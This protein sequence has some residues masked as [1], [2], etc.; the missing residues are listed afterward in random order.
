MAHKT[1]LLQKIDSLEGLTT[2]EKAQLKALLNTQ[3]KYGLVWEDKPEEVERQLLENLP[4]LVE[5]KERYIAASQPDQVEKTPNKKGISAAQLSLSLETAEENPEN[6]SDPG[7]PPS[8]ELEGASDN[9][10]APHHILI[11][12]D[13]LHALTALSFT[14]K[15]KI[16]VIYIDPPYNTGN[17]DF[18]YNDTFVDKE[19]SYRHSKWLSFMHKRLVLAKQLLKDTGVIFI[20]IDDNEQAQIKLLCD[21]VFVEQNFISNMIWSAGKKNDSKYISNSHEYVLAY[22]KNVSIIKSLKIKWRERKQGIDRIYAAAEKALLETHFDYPAATKSLKKWFKTLADNDPALAHSHYSV[23]D[24]GGVFFPDNISWPGGGGPTY[25][26]LHPITKKPVTVP[27]RGWVY[28]SAERMQEIIDAGRVIFGPD[29]KAV[30][31]LK[32]Y[33]KDREFEVPYSVIYKDGRAA[34][35]RL[36][37]ILGPNPFDNP[38]DE[39]VLSRLL[40]FSTKRN[41]KIL[42]FFAGSG[43]TLHAT[44][45]LNAEDGGSRQ[46]ILV[47]NNENNIAEEVCYERNKRVIEGYTKPNG[48]WVPGLKNNHLHYYK[49]E[50]VPSAR[51]QANRR[52]IVEAATEIICIRESAFTEVGSAFGLESKSIRLFQADSGQYIM[53]LYYHTYMDEAVTKSVGILQNLSVESGPIKIYVFAPQGERYEDEFEPVKDKINV[54][55]LP[56]AIYNAYQASLRRINVKRYRDPN[57][58][59]TGTQESPDQAEIDFSQPSNT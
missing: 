12:G 47:T 50:F 15:E 2:D 33:L 17:K 22:F 38:K 21:Q 14:H 4:V 8:G 19:D 25:E 10:T 20:S 18:K 57:F 40:K 36:R 39:T 48:E 27:S 59:E 56:E 46:C 6:Q 3:K 31:T 34:T 35:K 42:D 5:V 24:E 51:T 52:Q 28:G 11:E 53:V 7:P 58:S 30:P 26:V 16:D 13:N 45:Q 54:I 29:E 9:G 55:P 43:T 49:A 32:S 37:E 1:T 44:M 41:S 23:I